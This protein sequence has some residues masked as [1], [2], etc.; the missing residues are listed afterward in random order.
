LILHLF[1]FFFKR[2]EDLY[3]ENNKLIAKL[4]A[5]KQKKNK[6]VSDFA[7]QINLLN[8]QINNLQT[9][10]EGLHAKEQNNIDFFNKKTEELLASKEASESR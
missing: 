7:E 10:A 8:K 2:V 6:I 5:K 4:A 1:F 9:E 3:E